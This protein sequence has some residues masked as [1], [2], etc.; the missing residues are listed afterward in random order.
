MEQTMSPLLC[1]AHWQQIVPLLALYTLPGLA[2]LRWLLPRDSTLHPTARLLLALSVSAALPPLLLLLLQQVGLPWGRLATWLYLLLALLLA[3]WPTHADGRLYRGGSDRRW[4]WHGYRPGL[5]EAALGVVLL[6]VLLVRLYVVRDLP[7]G[8]FVDSHH[9]TLMAQL[10]VDNRGLFHSWEPYAPLG[11]FT[12]HFGFHSNAAFVHWI[13]GFSVPQ[14]VLIGGQLLNAAA[15][16]LAGGLICAL[17][18]RLWAGVWAALLVGFALNMPAFFVNWGRYTQLTG[19]V[20]LVTVAVAWIELA[21]ATQR[22]SMGR[23]FW[24]ALRAERGRWPLLLLAALLTT[25]MML[26][27][28][29]VTVFAAA[30]VGSA[31]LLAV[32]VQRSPVYGMLLAARATLAA[33]AAL[34]LALPWLLNLYSG[35]LIANTQAFVGGGVPEAR[36]EAV[37][38]MPAVHPYYVHG[39]VLLLGGLGLLIAGWRREW[40]IGLL[41]LWCALLVLTMVPRIVGLPGTGAI[42]YLTAFGT[43]YLPVAALAGHALATMQAGAAQLGRWLRL[44]Q[45]VGH[46]ALL[47]IL[48]GSMLAGVPQQADILTGHTQMLKRADV[49]AM[50]WIREHTAPDAHFLVNSSP[51]YGGTLLVGVDAGMWLTYLTG[52][53]STLP[54]LTYG[55]EAGIEPGFSQQTNALAA[56]LRGYPLTEA[57][58]RTID[59]AAIDLTG[60]EAL[61]TLREAGIDYVY[62]G[63]SG[64]IRPPGRGD[65]IDTALLRESAAFELVYDEGGAQI[66]RVVEAPIRQTSQTEHTDQSD[67]PD[68]AER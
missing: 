42:D 41:A 13:T 33:G 21:T 30:F 58:T 61:Y 26:T 45:A 57:L 53:T 65:E 66:F 50:E 63:A 10:L 44:P 5:A 39:G 23:Q 47:L 34:L 4:P 22:D 52:R 9:H 60:T 37:I 18:G 62:S 59:L 40:R 56:T 67:P 1:V 27:H 7:T 36:V 25:A 12:Y 68:Q 3:A 31:L 20:V 6:G 38:T 55:S 46:G 32:L 19:Q 64:A 8:L 29:R 35:K 14:S 49:A 54:P 2:L 16:A 51:A 15:A 48:L 43:L 28:Y 11:S 17:G 24:A